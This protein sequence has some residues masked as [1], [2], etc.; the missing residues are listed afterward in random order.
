MEVILRK[1]GL[2]RWIATLHDCAKVWA[3]GCVENTWEFTR[4]R[5]GSKV[6]LDFPNT[7]QSAKAFVFPQCEVLYHFRIE[8]GRAPE[9]TEAEPELEPV[10]LL[11]V[12][13]CDGR[14]M[15]RNDRVF[16]GGFPDPYYQARRDNVIL[17]GLACRTPPSPNC[18]CVSVGGLPHS[19]DG[20]DVLMT[21]LDGRYHVKAL[22]VRARDMLGR[23]GDLF[24]DAKAPDRADVADAHAIALEHPQRSL[25]SMEAVAAA[26]KL[27]F[28][29]PLWDKLA[30]ACI[31]CG[32]CTYLCPSCHCFD[33]NDE[34]TSKSPLAGMRVRTWDNCQFPDFTMHSSGHNPRE[35]TGGRLRQRICHKLL[36]FVENHEMQ[37]CTGCGRCITYCPVGIDIVQVAKAMQDEVRP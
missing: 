20:L 28:D 35:D 3:P 21:E 26:L 9:L 32:V 2:Q 29:S 36:Y 17:V 24:E 11:G 13:P 4:V 8:T 7:V 16:K 12:R 6:A 5:P 23:A 27:N 30:Q 14:A 37:Q 25:S 1:D 19:E 18:F 31:S 15:V 10:V 22:T 33:I 34:V